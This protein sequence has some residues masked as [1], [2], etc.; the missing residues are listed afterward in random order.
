MRTGAV[1]CSIMARDLDLNRSCDEL[2]FSPNKQQ[3]QYDLNA[4][5]MID[6]LLDI[7][8]VIGRPISQ[9]K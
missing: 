5:Y 9:Y 7:H 2:D 8:T 4:T 6:A 3:L 1:A